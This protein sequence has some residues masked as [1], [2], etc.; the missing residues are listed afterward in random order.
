MSTGGTAE[1]ETPQ[2]RRPVRLA[3]IHGLSA[4][5]LLLTGAF[6]VAVDLLVLAP[7]A[8]SFH[9]RWLTDRVRAAEVASLAVEAAPYA[10]VQDDLAGRLLRGVGADVVVLQEEG[11]RR[12]LRGQAGGETPPD[13]IDLRDPDMAAQVDQVHLHAVC[14]MTIGGRTGCAAPRRARDVPCRA[15]RRAP[16]RAVRP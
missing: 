15:V 13:L 1:I 16:A 4:R 14:R 3:W 5:L 9:E 11:I 10:T 12:L 8:A 2:A 6:A 7:A